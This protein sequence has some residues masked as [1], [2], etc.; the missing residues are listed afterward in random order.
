MTLYRNPLFKGELRNEPCPCGSG[1][2][3]KKCHGV[4]YAVPKEHREDF[5]KAQEE[6]N[7]RFLDA[8]A[9]A[10]RKQEEEQDEK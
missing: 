6:N 4:D 5:I 2:K 10:K 8:M 7:Q 9:E 3:T 1:K